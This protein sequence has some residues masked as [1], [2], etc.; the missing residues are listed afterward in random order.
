MGL[1]ATVATVVGSV[2]VAFLSGLFTFLGVRRK[3]KVDVQA[4]LNA[5]FNSL[6]E[7]LQE[8]RHVLQSERR[9]LRLM[10]IEQDRKILTLETRINRILN[11]TMTFHNFIV[12]NNLTPPAFDSDLLSNEDAS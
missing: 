12:Q 4:S 10:V 9:E 2:I 3:G 1:E 5:G 8:E 6:I 7:E 11:V